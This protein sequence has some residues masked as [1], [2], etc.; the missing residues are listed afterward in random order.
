[1]KD[2]VRN[3]ASMKHSAN[4]V[5]YQLFIQRYRPKQTKCS[6][7]FEFRRNIVQVFKKFKDKIPQN[8]FPAAPYALEAIRN[9]TTY[10]IA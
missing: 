2:S 1:M 7:E 10:F 4:K 6:K 3:G 9:A 8:T 5:I